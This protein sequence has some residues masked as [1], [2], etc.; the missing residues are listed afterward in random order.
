[1]VLHTYAPSEVSVFIAGVYEVS[2]FSGDSIITLTKDATTFATN[3]GAMGDVERTKDPNDIYTLTLHLSQTSPSN[4]ILNTLHNVDKA[5]A[6]GLFPLHMQDSSG[7]TFFISGTCWID[8]IPEASFSTSVDSREWILK[9]TDNL[10]NFSG[11]TEEEGLLSNASSII[12]VG[13][14]VLANIGRW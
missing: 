8:S 13:Q 11:N 3:V 1:M 5:T 10:Y 12:S 14:Q 4:T 6:R 2:G 7:N 9:A